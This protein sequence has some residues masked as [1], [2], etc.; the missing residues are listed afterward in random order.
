MKKESIMIRIIIIVVIILLL[1]IPL[2]MIGSLIDERVQYR[3]QAIHDINQSWADQQTIAGPVL[4]VEEIVVKKSKDGET[5]KSRNMLH[6]LPNDLIYECKVTPEI[7]N[8]GIYETVLYNAEIKIKG[9]FSK[10]DFIEN[11]FDQNSSFSQFVSINVSDMKG[12][13]ENISIKLNDKK[14]ELV[15]GLRNKDVLQKG[16]HAFVDLENNTKAKFEI[17]L[18][19][20]GSQALNFIPVGKMTKVTINSDWNNPGFIGEFLPSERILTEDGFTA[21]WKV[22]HFNRDYPQVWH[23]NQYNIFSSAFGV[24]LLLPVD[25][26]QKTTRTTKYGIMIIILTFITFFMIEVFSKKVIHPIQYLFV[27]LA[28]VIFYSLLLS[29]S[30]YFLFHYSYLISSLLVLILISFYVRSIYS[31]SRIGFII[32]GVLIFFYGFMY[33][34]L[35]LQDLSLLLGNIA[36]FII[37]AIIMLATRKINWFEVMNRKS[38]FNTNL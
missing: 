19:I 5:T 17:D 21:E 9:S 10:T 28:L 29:I 20:R 2:S 25:E 27:G 15:P 31:D 16:V 38:N 35:Q 6:M 13:K 36:L 4:T 22:N 26:Y 23:N 34:I 33:V 37:L 12:I 14:Y 1:L 8:R 18:I 3:N 11:L 24:N 32:S 30:E 7:R